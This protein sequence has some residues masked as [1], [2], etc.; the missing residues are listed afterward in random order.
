MTIREQLIEKC[1]ARLRQ[2]FKLVQL[3][4]W[5]YASGRKVVVSL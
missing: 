1:L 3:D 5:N 2:F 4:D